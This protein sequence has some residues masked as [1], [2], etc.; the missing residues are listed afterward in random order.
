M[1]VSEGFVNHQE[2][3][4]SEKGEGQADKNGDLEEDRTESHTVGWS[5]FTYFQ[6]MQVTL[7]TGSQQAGWCIGKGRSQGPREF[8][9]SWHCH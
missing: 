8:P 6:D 5:W 1:V 9:V 3:N 4:A 2:H 7:S